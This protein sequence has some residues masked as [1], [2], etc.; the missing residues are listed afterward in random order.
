MSDDKP[1]RH[2][3][4]LAM[5]EE[6]RRLHAKIELFKSVPKTPLIVTALWYAFILSCGAMVGSVI[7]GLVSTAKTNRQQSLPDMAIAAQAKIEPKYE[8]KYPCYFVRQRFFEDAAEPWE[9]WH[10]YKRTG[11]DCCNDYVT[12]DTDDHKYGAPVFETKQAAWN[13]LQ[14]WNLEA[15]R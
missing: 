7:T 9:K 15:C 2:E 13:F 10:V 1:L 4:Y 6:N 12:I 14:K 3:D 5:A 8:Q 11:K